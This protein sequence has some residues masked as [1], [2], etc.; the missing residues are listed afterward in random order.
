[1]NLSSLLEYIHRA[2]ARHV[3]VGWLPWDATIIT[4]EA[5]I[6]LAGRALSFN[7]PY[8]GRGGGLSRKVSLSAMS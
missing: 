1:M 7:K 5:K 3:F 4:P 2:V 6:P 8:Q